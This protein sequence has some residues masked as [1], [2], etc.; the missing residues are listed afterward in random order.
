[1]GNL[2]AT[3]PVAKADPWEAEPDN[4]KDKAWIDSRAADDLDE[5]EDEFDDDRFLEQYRYR[6]A[7][8]RPPFLCLR[9]D[10]AATE[11]PHS[12]A[13]ADRNE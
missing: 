11:Q 9:N 5:A 3:E 6:T 7:Y 13:A 12:C 2:P 4:A 10:T 1:M 8:L